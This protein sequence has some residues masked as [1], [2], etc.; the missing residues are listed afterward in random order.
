M[1]LPGKTSKTSAPAVGGLIKKAKKGLAKGKGKGL[2]GAG[3]L[4]KRKLAR[5]KL[6]EGISK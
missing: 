2:K 6:Q 3:P 5:R 4:K 1:T